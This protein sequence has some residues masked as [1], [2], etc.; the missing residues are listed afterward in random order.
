MMR[1]S[2]TADAGSSGARKETSAELAARLE[3]IALA[4]D[5]LVSRPLTHAETACGWIDL[6]SMDRMGAVIRFGSRFLRAY[7]ETSR[8]GL[9]RWLSSQEGW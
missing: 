7:M 2:P 3:G 9:T 1:F 5:F 4:S 8:R 6:F